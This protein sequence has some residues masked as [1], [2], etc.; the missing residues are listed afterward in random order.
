MHR[1][2]ERRSPVRLATPLR[3]LLATSLLATFASTAFAAPGDLY[4]TSD[5]ANLCNYYSGTTGAYQAFFALLNFGVGQMSI[6]FGATNNRALIG[7]TGGGVEEFD[8]TTG[9]YIKNYNPGG[10]WQWGAV[11]GPGNTVLIGDMSTQDVRKYDAT[12]G[13]FLGVLQSIPD[14]SDMEYGPGG[15]LWVC[16]FAGAKVLKL[17]P[18]SG[19]ILGILALPPFSQP[20]DIA[21]NPANNE[22]LVTDMTAIVCY[23]FDGNTFAPL[24]S[25][26]GTGWGRPHGIVISPYDGHVLIVDGVTG[27]VHEF[28]PLTYAEL[29]PAFLT[30]NIG[31]KI[32]DLEFRPGGAT[33]A[34]GTSWGR[35]KALYR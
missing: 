32:V 3:F 18:V 5:A 25:F 22:I 9:A 7:S 23:R 30:P 27:Q 33:P 13:A 17:D 24:G 11:Y 8:A 28:D 15:A 1:I 26:A 34:T 2:L 19:N 31:Q 12:T 6:H 4:V 29:N 14:P 10:G 20:N 35:V 16:S 21:F